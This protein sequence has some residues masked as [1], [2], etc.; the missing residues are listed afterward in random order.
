MIS[1]SQ[2]TSGIQQALNDEYK[3]YS[4]VIDPKEIPFSHWIS[5]IRKK[6]WTC[7]DSVFNERMVEYLNVPPLIDENTIFFRAGSGKADASIY[8]VQLLRFPTEKQLREKIKRYSHL[9]AKNTEIYLGIIAEEKCKNTSN[10]LFE[11][12]FPGVISELCSGPIFSSYSGCF[13]S[14]YKLNAS[15]INHSATEADYHTALEEAVHNMRY[16][17][18]LAVLKRI[19]NLRT[20][21]PEEKLDESLSLNTIFKLAFSIEQG[22]NIDEVYDPEAFNGL[23]DTQLAARNL[24]D[25]IQKTF[26]VQLSVIELSGILTLKDLAHTLAQKTAN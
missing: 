23:T 7:R 10:T 19:I 9:Q 20:H 4:G 1:V 14:V 6:L 26:A 12:E 3:S 17:N 25:D 2:L 18:M 15:A 22:V 13:L 5:A 24:V 21:L 8:G 11:T 16:E